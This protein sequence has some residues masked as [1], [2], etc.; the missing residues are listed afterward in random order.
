MSAGLAKSG[1]L[2]GGIRYV[3]SLEF[4]GAASGKAPVLRTG[5]GVY[6]SIEPAPNAPPTYA[7]PRFLLVAGRGEEPP[8]LE[9]LEKTGA[10]TSVVPEFSRLELA[11]FFS[12]MH[13]L[14]R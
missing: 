3:V 12:V 2:A 6:L 5:D 13:R 10:N 1:S 14:P 8:T 11:A 9:L 7:M 4:V